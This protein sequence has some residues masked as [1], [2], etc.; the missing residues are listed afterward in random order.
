[1][2][3]T[4]RISS[5]CNF[6]QVGQIIDEKYR[7]LRLIG[8][9]GVSCVYLAEHTYTSEKVAIKVLKPT[10]TRI[11]PRVKE[12]FLQEPQKTPRDPG[13]VRILDAG[14]DPNTQTPYIVMEYYPQNLRKLLQQNYPTKQLLEILVEVAK[15]IERFHR[16]G[17]IHLDLKPENILLDEYN[18]PKI[19]DFG[20]A[21]LKAETFRHSSSIWG[22]PVYT[23]P[24]VWEEEYSEKSD[25]Y[26]LGVILAEILTGRPYS[27]NIT[28]PTLRKLVEQATSLDPHERPTIKQFT[29]TLKQYLQPPSSSKQQHQQ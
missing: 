23:A 6:I 24:E 11:H 12:K 25:V 4:L 2:A 19:A 21:K 26:S 13:V 5:S 1:V 22:T 16:K 3:E 14:I 17:I 29:R 27:K 28:N 20:F 15:T 9:G 7:V 18:R 8:E 10:I